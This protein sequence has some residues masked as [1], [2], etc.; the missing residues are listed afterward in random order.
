MRE[1]MTVNNS[2][3]LYNPQKISG[4]DQ[5]GLYW[6]NFTVR[7]LTYDVGVNNGTSLLAV[8]TL[9][10]IVSGLRLVVASV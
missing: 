3:D 6:Q 5:D 8:Y 10:Y 7:I 9:Y 2:Y 4:Q 1:I